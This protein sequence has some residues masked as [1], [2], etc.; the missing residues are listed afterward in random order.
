[1]PNRTSVL[2]T[3]TVL[4]LIGAAWAGGL[5]DRRV[6]DSLAMPLDRIG[7]QLAGWSRIA[8]KELPSFTLNALDPTAYLLRTYQKG[9]DQLELFIAY[10]AQQRA[11]ESMHSP[12]H[13]LP[14]AGWEIWRHDSARVPVNGQGVNVN[15][16]SISN[17]GTR[18]LMLY[19]Y[20]SN[21]RIV[22][23]EYVGKLL[24][25]KDT[26]L[27]GHTAAALVR[28]SLPDTPSAREQAIQFASAAITGV[29][30]AM[31]DRNAEFKSW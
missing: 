31:G 19:W 25:A 3:A 30:Q 23:S 26:L 14:G 8:D 18:M 17:A 4:L 11:G 12:K 1:M 20:Q 16:Y 10:Y 13:C 5:A 27:S 24:L 9:P 22:A 21:G 29:R 6:P 28:V 15:M 7:D 2:F